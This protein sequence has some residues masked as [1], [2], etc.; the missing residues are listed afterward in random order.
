MRYFPVFLDLKEKRCIVVG[1]GAVAERKVKNL[2]KAGARVKVISPELTVP[3]SRLRDEKKISHLSR[4]YR[5][6]DLEGALLAIAA[7]NDRT[8]NER[9]F[10]EAT[11]NRIP[12]NVVDDPAHSSFIVPS[13]V[14]K[15]DLLVAVSTSG[16]S[17]ALARLLR[18]KLEREIGPEYPRFLSLLGRVR[19]KVLSRGL[20]QRENQR[21]FRR[22]V[23]DDLL[24]L[25]RGK[26]RREV[27]QRLRRAL[28]PGFSLKDLG[29][30]W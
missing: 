13:I 21:I 30:R 7:T 23:K 4:S 1:G 10:R 20:G 28:G 18:Q 27:D 16:R 19:K 9:V 25:I 6:K 2:L 29:F 26:K 5:R 12:V 14:H 11:A 15:K 3:L 22:L 8:I 24:P 17:P